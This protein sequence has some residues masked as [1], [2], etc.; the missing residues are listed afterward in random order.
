MNSK[1]ILGTAKFGINDYGFSSDKPRLSGIEMLR[2]ACDLGIDILDTS[3]RYGSAEKIIGQFH[4]TYKENFRVCTKVDNLTVSSNKSTKKI[5]NSVFNSLKDLN[6]NVIETLYL[7]QNELEIIS[8]K[9]ITKAVCQLKS[10]GLVK[11]IGVS[12]YNKE[13]CEFA[14][15]SDDYDVI[16]LPVSILDSHILSEISGFISSKEIVGR[17]LFLQGVLF[18]RNDIYSKV[19]QAEDLFSKLKILDELSNKYN[20]SLLNLAVAFVIGLPL[21]SNIVVGTSS[22]KNL[23]KIIKASKIKLPNKLNNELKIHSSKYKIWGNPRN[24]KDPNIS[25]EGK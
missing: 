11:K 9:N 5:Y 16:Q 19:N 8:D 7:H 25:M 2:L 13:E 6:V 17:S 10:E 18:N 22:K 14:L 24:W 3:P 15:K 20:Y 4:K 23:I 21:V 12:V 1:V